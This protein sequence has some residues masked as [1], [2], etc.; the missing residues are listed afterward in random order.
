MGKSKKYIIEYKITDSFT[1]MDHIAKINLE[2]AS[3]SEAMDHWMLFRDDFRA[4][5]ADHIELI[6]IKLEQSKSG[7]E[8]E[9]VKWIVG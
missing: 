9:I 8:L 1:Y 5:N 2:A 4:N 6:S 3:S 7:R